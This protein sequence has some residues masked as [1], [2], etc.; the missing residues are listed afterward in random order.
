MSNRNC[1]AWFS[2]ASF[3]SGR[4]GDDELIYRVILRNRRLQGMG[5]LR[6]EARTVLRRLRASAVR[7][8]PDYNY[9]QGMFLYEVV[10][11]VRALTARR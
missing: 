8:R 6:G 5:I 3:M 9:I 1:P 7:G 2:T 4:S 11:A 10:P